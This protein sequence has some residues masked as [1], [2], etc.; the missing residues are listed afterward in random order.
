LLIQPAYG[1]NS[2]APLGVTVI[3]VAA[4][5]AET[6]NSAQQSVLN[7]TARPAVLGPTAELPVPHSVPA[8]LPGEPYRCLR[9]YLGT[10]EFHG[11]GAGLGLS[12]LFESSG[13]R[14]RVHLGEQKQQGWNNEGAVTE[15]R[16]LKY[17]RVVFNDGKYTHRI[18]C[19]FD[20]AFD[21]P[22]PTGQH[23]QIAH[24]SV[25]L[26][27]ERRTVAERLDS[28]LDT[29]GLGNDL[30][31]FDRTWVGFMTVSLPHQGQDTIPQ[32]WPIKNA[33][34]FEGPTPKHLSLGVEWLTEAPDLD[35]VVPC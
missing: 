8:T 16:P 27:L 18:S 30:P 14:A 4:C 7:M 31:S 13:Y 22:W 11:C 24:V 6:A 19:E 25:D 20:E 5:P 15:K 1:D 26:W 10:L 33:C 29:V 35:D 32:P 17:S 34:K 3:S 2:N 12:G 23:E 9:V 21:L 28:L